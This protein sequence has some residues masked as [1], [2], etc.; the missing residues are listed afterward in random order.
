MITAA[1]HI[2]FTRGQV[3]RTRSNVD[4][5]RV[6]NLVNVRLVRQRWSTTH[7]ATPLVQHVNNQRSSYTNRDRQREWIQNNIHQR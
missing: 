5:R 2:T 6:W 1:V 4:V 3:T 7:H